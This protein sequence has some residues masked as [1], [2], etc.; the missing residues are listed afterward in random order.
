MYKLSK[1]LCNISHSSNLKPI[2]NSSD[3]QQYFFTCIWKFEFKI[4]VTTHLFIVCQ[5]RVTL[6]G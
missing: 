5:N 1:T 2:S 4:E 6:R 3:F